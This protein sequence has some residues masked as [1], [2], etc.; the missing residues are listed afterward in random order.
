M[1][2]Y[3]DWVEFVRLLGLDPIT[4]WIEYRFALFASLI[5]LALILLFLVYSV[6]LRLRGVIANYKHSFTDR[7]AFHRSV[8]EVEEKYHELLLEALGGEKLVYLVP[9]IAH[10]SVDGFRRTVGHLMLTQKSLIF[11]ADWRKIE[12]PLDSFQDANVRDG[13]KHMELKLIVNENKKPIFHLLG[14]SRDHAQELFMKMHS[15]RVLLKENR[16]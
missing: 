8:Y 14:I 5:G 10:D 16:S 12:Y 13:N 15:F 11:A 6:A 7:M 2:V 3:P 1:N 4:V 9:A